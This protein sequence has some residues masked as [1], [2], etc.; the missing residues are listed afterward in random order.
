MA[1]KDYS[2]SPDFAGMVLYKPGE[3]KEPNTYW[4]YGVDQNGELIKD[5]ETNEQ[6]FI[7]TN[8]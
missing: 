1:F 7:L 6:P 4:I 2:P 5:N 3:G 8:S